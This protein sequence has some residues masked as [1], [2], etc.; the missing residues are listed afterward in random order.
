MSRCPCFGIKFV[1]LNTFQEY[2]VSGL[3]E[4]MLGKR[5]EANDCFKASVKINPEASNTLNNLG[6]ISW[7]EGNI[8]DAF[9]YFKKALHVHP[10][11]KVYVI[12]LAAL[13]ALTGNIEKAKETC[14]SFLKKY[15][16]KD[17]EVLFENPGREITEPSPR[18]CVDVNPDNTLTDIF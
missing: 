16:D 5:R 3:K 7:Q 8:E 6:V 9:R 11:N 17:I 13:N 18:I 12:N 14:K 10:Y 1:N 15:I 2:F 4:Y